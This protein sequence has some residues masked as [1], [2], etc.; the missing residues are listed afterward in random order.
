MYWPGGLFCELKA[1]PSV[2]SFSLSLPAVF[3]TEE[4]EQASWVDKVVVT[5][6]LL[7]RDWL[8]VLPLASIAEE[9]PQ[10]TQDAIRTVFEVKEI[11]R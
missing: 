2:L 9:S 8:M 10:A 11:Y 5:L 7:L 3:L 4:L 1:S 6:L